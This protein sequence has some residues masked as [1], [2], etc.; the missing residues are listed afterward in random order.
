MPVDEAQRGQF[1]QKVEPL[2]RDR[3]RTDV[4]RQHRA[5]ANAARLVVARRRRLFEGD[6]FAV[7]Q[8][9][10]NVCVMVRA[11]AGMRKAVQRRAGYEERQ[12]DRQQGVP[13]H[14]LHSAIGVRENQVCPSQRF[15][16]AYDAGLIMRMIC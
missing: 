7:S 15:C 13:R 8:V 3:I 2:R 16:P 4:L 1:N 14:R 12:E 6:G 9:V 11:L 5:A 10:C